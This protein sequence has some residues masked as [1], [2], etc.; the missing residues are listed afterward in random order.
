MRVAVLVIAK[1]KIIKP[2]IKAFT[3]GIPLTTRGRPGNT[4][5]EQLLQAM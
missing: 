5:T 4:K 3:P 1:L 2:L